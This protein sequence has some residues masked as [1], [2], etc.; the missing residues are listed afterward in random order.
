MEPHWRLCG[1]CVS[2]VR[3]HQDDD[4]QIT[5]SGHNRCEIQRRV[6]QLGINLSL[7]HGQVMASAVA[8]VFARSARVIARVAVMVVAINIARLLTLRIVAAGFRMRM[9]PAATDRCMNQ[10]R[11]GN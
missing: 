4:M 8:V 5:S 2:T 9:M 3:V 11:C 6:H 7:L 10:Q 1:C